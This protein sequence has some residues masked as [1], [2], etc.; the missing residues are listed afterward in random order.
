MTFTIDSVDY[1]S[2]ITK[3]GYKTSVTPVYGASVTTLDG[4]E[5]TA[6]IRYKGAVSV[7]LRPLEATAQSTL[8]AS[9]MAGTMSVTYTCLQRGVDV[10]ATM[11]LDDMS[12][13]LVLINASHTFS[14]NTELTFIQ[15]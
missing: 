14:G 3:Y 13:E 5:H 15:L 6:V 10:T 2:Y 7:V 11:K 12:A 1:S 9:L 8:S 4:V